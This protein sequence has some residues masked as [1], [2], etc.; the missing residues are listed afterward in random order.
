MSREGEAPRHPFCNSLSMSHGHPSDFKRNLKKEIA[1]YFIVVLCALPFRL[2]LMT[3]FADAK[4]GFG[5]FWNQ[6]LSRISLG[7]IGAVFVSK[8]RLRYKLAL[9]FVLVAI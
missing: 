7:L 5:F 1:G 9:T 2:A 8:L 4:D 6:Y 3:Q